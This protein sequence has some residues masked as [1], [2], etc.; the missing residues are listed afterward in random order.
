[1]CHVR[2]LIHHTHIYYQTF[3]FLQYFTHP[4]YLRPLLA[5]SRFIESGTSTLWGVE[6]RQ[7]KSSPDRF[8]HNESPERTHVICD[9]LYLVR[10]KPVICTRMRYPFS[11]IHKHIRVNLLLRPTFKMI[12]KKIKIIFFYS[13]VWSKCS[14]SSC[15][16][17]RR[18][19]D[20]NTLFGPACFFCFK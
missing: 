15:H 8:L 3:I 18:T 7:D 17:L 5:G 14:C 19:G 11:C 10:H 13:Y 1:M 16:A 6:R 20:R 4:L 12:L 9:N 2:F